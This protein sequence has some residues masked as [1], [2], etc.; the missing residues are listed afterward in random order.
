M[1]V[2]VDKEYGKAMI[3]R[4]KQVLPEL[5]AR[6]VRMLKLMQ[7]TTSAQAICALDIAIRRHE[8]RQRD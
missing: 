5:R 3:E 2:L 4:Q 7:T 6:R 1:T 8:E